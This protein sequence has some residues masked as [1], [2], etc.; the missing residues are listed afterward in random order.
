MRTEKSSVNDF[1]EA[2]RVELDD[3][4]KPVKGATVV[5]LTDKFRAGAQSGFNRLGRLAKFQK[6]VVENVVNFNEL[7]NSYLVWYKP[8]AKGDAGWEYAGCKNYM[9]HEYVTYVREDKVRP[10]DKDKVGKIKE[11]KGKLE[12]GL[13]EDIEL[14]VAFDTQLNKRV[15]VDGCKRTIALALIANESCATFLRLLASK[16]QVVVMQLSSQWAHCIY[17]CDFLPFME[18]RN[19][20]LLGMPRAQLRDQAINELCSELESHRQ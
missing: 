10:N 12:S 14:L 15:I 13:C 17:P 8:N 2:D 19:A 6:L 11:L 7:M 4:G 9:V 3:K 20:R 1:L 5:K 16:H 18:E